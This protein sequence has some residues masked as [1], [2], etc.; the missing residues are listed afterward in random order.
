MKKFSLILLAFFALGFSAYAAVVTV[1]FTSG[2]TIDGRLIE[3]ND[4][5]LVLEESVTHAEMQLP[6]EAV[7]HCVVTGLGRYNSVNGKFVPTESVQNKLEQ[8]RIKD[9]EHAQEV[10]ARAADPNNVIGK[11][12]KTTGA[13][14]LGVGIPS[15]FIGAIL[16]VAGSSGQNSGSSAQEITQKAQTR[17]NCMTAGCVLLPFGAAL[18][19]VGIP[20]HV[21]GKRI[22]EMSLNYAGNGAALTLNF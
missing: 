11:A 5:L 16:M 8:K 17:A 19:I 15:L 2:R 22:A 7:K 20:L 1:T 21:H 13:T 18:T 12:L 14:A 6:P 4:S 10:Q 9:E 3:I